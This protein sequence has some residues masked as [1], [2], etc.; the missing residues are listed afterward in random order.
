MKIIDAQLH[1]PAP[2]L[3][4]SQHELS[5]QYDVLNEITFAYLDALGISGVILFSD[6]WG[7]AAAK[8]HPE[9]FAYVPHISPDVPDVESA[10]AASKARHSDGLLGLRAVIGWPLDGAEARRLE[11]GQWNP[12][13][14]ACEKHALPLFLFATRHLPL[15][16]PVAER[17]RDLPLIIDHIGLPQPPMD[18]PESP[19]F[20]N[21]NQ[22]LELARF[23]NVAVKLSGMPGMS[24]EPYPFPDLVPHL[25]AI[26]DAFGADRLMWGTDIGRFYGRIG[27]EVFGSPQARGDYPGKH[28]YAEALGFIQHSEALSAE[29]KE[30][31]LGGTVQRLLGWPAP[32][33]SA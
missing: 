20:K 11:A 28:T 29:E 18:E 7:A 17:Y 32:P 22:L 31:I 2:W 30:A 27:L 23:P 8:A 19:P 5:T 26:V 15:A 21:L 6:D 24:R 12:V 10:I 9:R 14:E 13:F 25:R 3:D 16:V 33:P 1:D 4:W